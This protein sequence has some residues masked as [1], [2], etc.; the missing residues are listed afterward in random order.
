MNRQDWLKAKRRR[1]EERMDMLFAPTYDE[2]WGNYSNASH[3]AMLE[4]FLGLC[5]S[6]GV[7]LDAACGTG[8]YWP[9]ILTS[10]RTPYGIDQSQQMLNRA[11]TKFPDVPIEKLGMQE[12]RFVDKFD[13]IIC[14]DGMEFVFP[15]DWPLV[16]GNFYRALKSRGYLYFTVELIDEADLRAA[17]ESAKQQGL[18]VVAG[19]MAH[20]DGYHYYPAMEQVREWIRDADLELLDEA[21]G[22]D[23]QHFLVRKA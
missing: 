13:G 8:R 1:A 7:I 22:D 4:R 12:M 21:T 17:Q 14:M 23:Y 15:E 16:L 2:Q 20:E 19:E 6:D 10:G 18:P 5:P 3:R 9:I 11:H